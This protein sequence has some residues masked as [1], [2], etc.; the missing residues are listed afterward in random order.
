M[1]VA[2]ASIIADVA[3]QEYAEISLELLLL[4]P[5]LR[6]HLRP[7]QHRG[8]NVKFSELIAL[9][10]RKPS[11]DLG[12]PDCGAAETESGRNRKRPRPSAIAPPK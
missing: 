10:G 8:E 2:A 7:L 12:S 5:Y 4:H 1:N 3:M 11:A 9:N 6:R